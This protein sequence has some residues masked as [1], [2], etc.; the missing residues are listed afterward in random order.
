MNSFA[1]VEDF[2]VF[3][4]FS[5]GMVCVS[6]VSAFREQFCLQRAKERFDGRIIVAVA[7]PTHAGFNSV[8]FEQ[9]SE[10][11]AGVLATAV[12]VME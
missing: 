4:D 3:E 2:D 7:L 11:L 6:E 5:A 9:V 12:A 1:V 10:R 8:P